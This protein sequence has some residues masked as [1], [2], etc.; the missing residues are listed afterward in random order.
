[1]SENI[2]DLPDLL[3]DHWT[4]R[5]VDEDGERL[6]CE[7]TEVFSSPKLWARHLVSVMK[8]QTTKAEPLSEAKC[9]ICDL[10]ETDGRHFDFDHPFTTAL[11][12]FDDDGNDRP[13][14]PAE[15]LRVH[16]HGP[17]RGA[18]PD[19]HCPEQMVGGRLR[20][21]CMD[22]AVSVEEKP[23]D[24]FVCYEGEAKLLLNPP[25]PADKET[26]ADWCV[27]CRRSGHNHTV[28]KPVAPSPDETKPWETWQEIP[29][30]VKYT[31]NRT[32]WHIWMNL[33]GTRHHRMA[34]GPIVPWKVSEADDPTM[35][36]R[37]PFVPAERKA[38]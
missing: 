12:P 3:A 37:A 18:R 24:D 38:A 30:W 21:E 31:S 6:V 11:S 35:A 1:M 7:C 19:G 34:Y 26:T 8:S 13:N 33:E 5:E 28:H 15:D 9:S 14:E 25:P 2:I 23:F 16:N 22:A 4:T 10:V 29:D 27:L 17:Y 20:G 32:P 36:M